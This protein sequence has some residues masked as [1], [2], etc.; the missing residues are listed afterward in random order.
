MARKQPRSG[1]GVRIL[2]GVA[3]V[4]AA[5]V[6]AV[7]ASAA[8]ADLDVRPIE[9]SRVLPVVLTGEGIIYILMLGGGTV[10][11][12]ILLLSVLLSFVVR[13]G[14]AVAAGALSPQV[15]GD[16]LASAQFY[17]ASYWPAAV[18]QVLMMAVALRL[19]RPLIATRTRRRRKSRPQVADAL[20]DSRREA[21]RQDVLLKAL[22]ENTDEP[23]ISP[24]VLE[25][26]QIGDL[27][28]VVESEAEEEAVP[29]APALPF[30]EEKP[31]EAETEAEAETDAEAEPQAADEE[32]LPP[33]VID[34]TP[35]A[36][37]RASADETEAG[38][39]PEPDGVTEEAREEA[40][41]EEQVGTEAPSTEAAEEPGELP[42]ETA[43]GTEETAQ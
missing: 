27:A 14:I 39:V 2:M 26:R 3:R 19:I 22:A 13:A 31:E 24:T 20:H 43:E 40:A 5:V 18:A 9:F 36:A 42:E 35:E 32:A 30:D 7:A 29:E 34:A 15:T 6:I 12:P 8:L 38:E 4:L 1:V 11:A 17:Y 25:E 10:A 16:L 21:E 41:E 28:E 37:M 23:P 33:G